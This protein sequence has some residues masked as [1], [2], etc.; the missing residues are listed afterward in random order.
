[1]NKGHRI[2]ILDAIYLLLMDSGYTSN[3]FSGWYFNRT[4]YIIIII[5]QGTIDLKD[6]SAM[7]E[8]HTLASLSK[9]I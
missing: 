3:F 5:L 6:H 2:C 8:S 1:M 7:T 9:H 4:F